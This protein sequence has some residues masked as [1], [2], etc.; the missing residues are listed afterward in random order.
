MSDRVLAPTGWKV[1]ELQSRDLFN[2]CFPSGDS[3]ALA[4]QAE[5]GETGVASESGSDEVVEVGRMEMFEEKEK[6]VLIIFEDHSVDM[7]VDVLQK[8]SIH[9][10][11]VQERFTM[12]ET[13]RFLVKK[14]YK[15][16]Y[17]D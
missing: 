4:Y 10:F 8:I 3:A 13:V 15:K 9:R 7:D 6:L 12:G 5:L 2:E 11:W 16:T 1:P 17:Q 14:L